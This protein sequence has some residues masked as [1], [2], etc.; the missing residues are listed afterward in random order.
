MVMFS[1]IQEWPRNLPKRDLALL[2][3][4]L[5]VVLVCSALVIEDRWLYRFTGRT[6][7]LREAAEI[8]E[9]RND[10]RRKITGDIV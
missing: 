2:V 4:A 9:T 8:A 5:G 1:A 6:A 7:G 10:V 3:W